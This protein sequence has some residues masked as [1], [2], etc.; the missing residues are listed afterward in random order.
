VLAASEIGERHNPKVAIPSIAVDALMLLN[1]C[2]GDSWMEAGASTHR[3]RM[4]HDLDKPGLVSEPR[5]DYVLKYVALNDWATSCDV[6]SLVVELFRFN[7]F[8]R[9]LLLATNANGS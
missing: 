1:R 8:H 2:H 6:T 7:A 5:Q 4:R 3:A 9:P